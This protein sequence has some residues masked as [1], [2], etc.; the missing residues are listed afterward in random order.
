MPNCKT[1]AICNQ[2]GGAGILH[3]LNPEEMEGA[4]PPHPA[5]QRENGV[6]TRVTPFPKTD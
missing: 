4:A 2:K 6:T 5:Q 3:E 1:I